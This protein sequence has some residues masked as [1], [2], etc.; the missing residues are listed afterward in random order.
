MG[1][2][3]SFQL[4]TFLGEEI[5]NAFAQAIEPLIEDKFY[6]VALSTG[7]HLASYIGQNVIS[8]S[9]GRK[10]INRICGLDP[11]LTCFYPPIMMKHI[12]KHDA[13]FVDIIHSDAGLYGSPMQCGHVDFWPN[14][15]R[16]V[17]PGGRKGKFSPMSEEGYFIVETK[18]S[19]FI[20][21]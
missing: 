21:K 6:I 18:S 3:L 7:A 11:F 1:Y 13:R 15:G 14:K 2:K 12:T 8:L 5:H 20:T 16:A 9:R 10:H 17:Q 19:R 4:G